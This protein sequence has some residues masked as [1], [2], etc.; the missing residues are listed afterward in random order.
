MIAIKKKQISSLEEAQQTLFVLVFLGFLCFKELLVDLTPA[1]EAS[2][3]A[4]ID[5]DIRIDLSAHAAIE[6]FFRIAFVHRI[7]FQ[8]IL[9]AKVNG[10][11]QPFAVPVCPKDQAMSF[12][13]QFKEGIKGKYLGWS[14]L[15]VFVLH[16]GA[17][18]INGYEQRILR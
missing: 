3:V 1:Q 11:L 12:L 8:A 13:L 16:N 2:H 17:V 4:V 14:D 10:L 18:K 15:R 5:E 9:L 6:F 7:E